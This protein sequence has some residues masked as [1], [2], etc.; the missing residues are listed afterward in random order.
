M[1]GQLLVD[2]IILFVSIHLNAGKSTYLRQIGLLTIMAQ[3]GCFVPA[4]YASFR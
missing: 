2:A 3:C 4:E 1:S